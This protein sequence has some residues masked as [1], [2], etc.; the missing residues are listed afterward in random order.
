MF[1][2]AFGI[3]KVENI[4]IVRTFASNK[5]LIKMAVPVFLELILGVA[6][7]YVN[8][9]MLAQIPLAS[10]AVGQANQIA[11]IFIVSFSVLSSSSLILITQLTG[12]GKTDVAE[13]IYPL[14]FYLN[15]VIGFIVTALVMGLSPVIFPIMKVNENVV[16]FAIRYQLV[17]GPSL[18]F[19]ALNQVFSAYLRANKKMV[20]PTLISFSTNVVNAG[21]NAIVLWAIP[22]LTEMDKLTGVALATD[23]SRLV[24]L[25]LAVFFFYRH[26][27]ASLSWKKL[28]PFPK[29]LLHKQ[30]AIGLPT[31]GETLS[32]NFSQLV[33][34]IIV[35]ASVMPLEQNLRSYLMTFTSII[36]LFA[37]GTGIA[38]QVIEGNLIGEGKKEDAAKLVKDVGIMARTVSF[39]MSLLITAI[40][41]PVFMALMGPA[42]NDPLTNVNGLTIQDCGLM[43]VFCMLIDIVL[44]QGRATNLVYVKGLETSGDILFPVLSSI[45]TSWLFTVGASAL[46]CLVFDLGIYGA[47]IGAAL[48]ECVR[49]I[50][51]VIRWHKGGWKKRE[52]VKNLK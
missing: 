23:A 39:I 32:Y 41:Y 33:L 34:T 46:L 7:G 37:N 15:L 17:S 3:M 5:K 10:N 11:N 27:H 9:F 50:L 42:V 20:Q 30:L 38:M 18:I 21:I 13:K 35:N 48:D 24:S 36:Y 44:D 8:Q 26:V 4:P 47:F 29:E 19:Y 22:S 49:G 25:L 6:M 14:A 16:P 28:R 2:R 1:E 43:A 51:Y 52:L 31:A 40:A 12:S 45:F